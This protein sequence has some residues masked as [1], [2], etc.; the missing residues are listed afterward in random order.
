[1]TY[2][3]PEQLAPAS[4]NNKVLT[5]QE[6]ENVWDNLP[7]AAL[8]AHATTHQHGGSDEIATATPGAN[9]IPKA[10]GSGK[11][12]TGWLS[13]QIALADLSDVTAKT[14]T[15]TIVVMQTGPTIADPVINA[16]ASGDGPTVHLFGSS[17]PLAVNYVSSWGNVTGSDP[18]IEARG[19][20]ADINLDLRP[21]G[22][23]II[24]AGGVEV[25]TISGSQ[26]L[27]NKTL[28]TPTI[29]D[30]TNAQHNH[31]NAA[32]GGTLGSNIVTDAIL[33]DSGPLSV[34]GRTGPTTGNPG[35][36][37]ATDG[38]GEVLR[39][40]G[41]A[42][43]FGKLNVTTAVTNGTIG[44][45]LESGATTP[46]W[47]AHGV[48]FRREMQF[49]VDPGAI[50]GTR[51]GLTTAPTIS[52]TTISNQDG[53]TRPIIR[54]VTGGSSGNSAGILSGFDVTRIG[55]D[56]EGNFIVAIGN[57][58]TSYRCWIGFTTADLTA[59]ATPTTQHVAA[60]SYDTGR[61]GTVF[62]RTVTNDGVGAATVT[63]TTTAVTAGQ[64]YH[65]RIVNVSTSSVQFYID[66]TLVNTHSTTLPGATTTLG[67]Q[68][69]CTTLTGATRRIDFTRV[70]IMG[71]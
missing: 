31:S 53:S 9:A 37:S 42:L 51:V 24:K 64:V 38:A 62:F 4:V 5:I 57:T 15:G 40:S 39:E 52:G 12:A 3:T 20:D 23:G 1:M 54:C 44:Y 59:V 56:S 25:V 22:T 48:R 63:A 69:S 18:F 8:P 26:T 33:R 7:L 68:C 49:L 71:Q 27:T 14:G 6:S 61:D 58:I 50:T 30:L 2:I 13:E 70:G 29:G 43:A 60:F 47:T 11:L 32:G 21:R 65:F 35:D 10:D 41:S 46:A 66:N 36:I 16:I 34:I 45:T 19:T 17:G 67:F 55:W 28:T